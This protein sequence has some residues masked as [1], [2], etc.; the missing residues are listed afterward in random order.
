MATQDIRLPSR[1]RTGVPGLDDILAGGFAVGRVFLLEGSPGTGK[2]TIALRFLM[3]G[4]AKGEQGLYVTLSETANELR[5]AAASHGWVLGD[6]IEVFEVAPPESLLDPDQQQSLLYASDLELGETTRSIFEA[7]DRTKARRIVIDSLSE[8]RLLGQSSLRYRRQILAMKHFFARHGATVLMLDDLTSEVTDKTVH[9]VAHG[10]VRLEEIAPDY[11][12]E[13]RRL[14]VIKYRAQA[15]RGGYHDFTIRKGGVQVFPRLVA[16]EHR[17]L[18]MRGTIQ[19]GIPGLDRLLGGGVEQ[20][21]STVLMGPPG[22]G[23]SLISLQFV[24]EAIKAGGKAAMFIFD[25]EIGLLFDRA[26]PLGFDLE[27]LRNSG[28]LTITQLDAAE[29]SP[30]EFAHSV[31]ASVQDADVKTVVIDSLN[32][33]QAAMPQENSLILHMHELL[34]FLNRHGVSTFL[35]VAQQGM[36]GDMR[37]PVDIT[38]LADTV[39]LLRFFEARGAVRRAI[40]VIK[41]RTG[42][43]EETI[44]EFWIDNGVHVG[45]PLTQ[46]HGVLRGVP[47][48]VAEDAVAPRAETR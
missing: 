47:L 42:K 36:M 23:K 31:R 38:Y 30:G 44:R 17:Q 28:K 40:S 32:G 41:K 8:I 15:F 11:G 5:M 6:L 4:A 43:H 10:V 21:S 34:Q 12:S 20:G 13:R 37:S 29:L 14:R 9:S 25:E 1:A 46:F 26:R 45:E 7:V 2:T 3:E 27:A 35:T 48:I 16:A 24:D 33:Y 39:I 19:S 22:C 18:T